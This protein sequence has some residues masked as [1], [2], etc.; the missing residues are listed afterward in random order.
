MPNGA[1]YEYL[2]K[3]PDLDRLSLVSDYFGTV[4]DLLNNSDPQSVPGIGY[5]SRV[6]IPAPAWSGSWEFNRSET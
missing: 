6:D 2:H 5:S 1:L 3:H 4:G